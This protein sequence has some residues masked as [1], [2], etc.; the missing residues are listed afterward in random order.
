[1]Y[2]LILAFTIVVDYFAGILIESAKVQKKRKLYL[3]MSLV[4]NIGVLAF[5]KYFNFLNGNISGISQSFGY[6]NHIPYLKIL[7]PIGLSFHTFQAMSYTIEI[8]RGNFKAEKHFGIYAL[9]VMFYPQLVAGPIERPQNILPQLH[10]KKVYQYKNVASGLRLMLWGF[11]KKIVIADRLGV[12]VDEVFKNYTHYSGISLMIATLF[13]TFEIYA[14]FS[15][16]T[17]IAIGSAEVMGYDLVR[18]F[19]YPFRSKN[20]SDYWRR[21]HISLSTW[22]NDYLYTE[23]LLNTRY[24]GKGAV[25][26]GLLF[27]FFIS[28]LWHGAGWTFIAWGLF[29][30]VAVSYEFLTKKF[31]KKISKKLP[32]FIY[33][34]SSI[35]LTFLFI[36]FTFI[37]FRAE[38]F[39]KAFYFLRH[40]FVFDNS[41]K[42]LLGPNFFYHLIAGCFAIVLLEVFQGIFKNDSFNEY[43]SK[44]NTGTRWA[45]Y[46]ILSLAILNFG[47]FGGKQFIYFQF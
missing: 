4:A 34:N 5:F 3:V 11:F 41:Y 32:A 6:T 29:H 24:W 7:L 43:L 13:F 22:F 2:I 14:D 46:I 30:G 15:G 18:N 37:F 21:W 25:V 39:S 45:F 17:D 1:M 26:F 42:A 33:R 47:Y 19:N 20:V 28:G 31:R 36:N 44:K 12:I 35:L 16:Y 9:Y 10:E 38:N 27:T 8:Y 23:I 40:L